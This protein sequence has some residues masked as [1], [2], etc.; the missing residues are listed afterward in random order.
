M[1]LLRAEITGFGKY[2]NKTIDFTA[3]NQ[4]FY[5]ANEAGKSTLYQFI[6]AMLFGFL[7]KEDGNEILNR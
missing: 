3:G 6:M 1:Q 4:L 5:G 7:L 2:R